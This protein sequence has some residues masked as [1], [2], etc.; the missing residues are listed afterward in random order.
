VI[1][2]REFLPRSEL[3]GP[4]V[5]HP[6]EGRVVGVVRGR[7][8]FKVLP[9]ETGGA[10]AVLEQQVPPGGGPP[11]HVHRHETEL[12]YVL[13]GE[14]AFTVAGQTIRAAAGTFVAGPRDIPHTFR[15][16]GTAEG[17]LLLMVIPGRFANYFL[18]VDGVPDDDVAA[19]RA[20][21]ARYDVELLPEE[22]VAG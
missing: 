21:C 18:E 4:I 9:E 17:R 15:N 5:R 19:I 3:A 10:Y 11:L 1:D 6:G 22:T 14:F 20:L 8:T 16:V 2:P 12:F 13:Q 7:T